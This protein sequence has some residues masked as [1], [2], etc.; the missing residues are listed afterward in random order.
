MTQGFVRQDVNAD[1]FEEL[2]M[3][4]ASYNMS[5]ARQAGVFFPTMEVNSKLF[6]A[7][8]IVLVGWLAFGSS[9][10][11]A[12]GEKMDEI[13]RNLVGF[14][15]MIP[16]FFD[17]I[18]AVSRQ[19]N[20]A[21]TAMAGAERVFWVLDSEPTWTDAA[22]A[23]PM[24]AIEGRVEFRNVN[25][26]YVEGKPVLH[27]VSFTVEPGQTIALV[28]HTGSG[29]SSIINLISKFYPITGGEVLI[30][31]VDI[32]TVDSKSLQQQM[33]I[34]LQQNFLFTGTVMDNI[35]F[36]RPDAPNL[37]V[38]EAA[39]KLDCVDL[40]DRLPD[41]F[42]TRVGE[43]GTGISLGQRQLICFTRAMLAD[44]RILILDEATSS[45]DTITEVRIQK[46]LS[47]LLEGRTSFVVAH[48]LSTIRHA[49]LVL[50][51][52]Q[53]RIVERGTH[54]E[55]L[56]HGGIYANLYRQFIRATEA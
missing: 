34:V 16:L 21:L 43:G 32:N 5:A 20:M 33:G 1:L 24:P 27:D 53:G 42:M 18:Q 7:V 41:S 51:L 45:V 17:P 56:V 30:D 11:G 55:L 48:R 4:H 37:E 8:I 6:I 46:A 39:T 49:D 52:D 47:I 2:V 54:E 14:L 9:S 25:F 40:L 10:A 23:R 3:D 38:I 15:M 31:G 35:R 26:E 29:K 22:D 13:V 12:D 19:Y 28:G 36:G 44:P 50:V